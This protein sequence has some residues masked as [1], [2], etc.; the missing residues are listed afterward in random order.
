MSEL[1]A[2]LRTAFENEGYAV[3]EVS[4]NRDRVRVAVLDTASPD[5]LQA[6][7]YDVV[8]EHDVL[9]LDVRSESADGQDGVTTVVSFRYRG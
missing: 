2:E 8:D 5:D 9:G 7:T 4:V 3:S 6:V 1:E